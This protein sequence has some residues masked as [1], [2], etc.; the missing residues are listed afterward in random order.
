MTQTKVTITQVK[1]IR[2]QKR[3]IMTYIFETTESGLVIMDVVLVVIG[4]KL[5]TMGGKLGK[6]KT[7]CVNWKLNS[8][9]VTNL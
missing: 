5:I 4:S 8:F 7:E 2:A 9:F 1:V 6:G 3:I